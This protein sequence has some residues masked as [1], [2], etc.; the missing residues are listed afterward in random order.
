MRKSL[1]TIQQG[2]DLSAYD[3]KDHMNGSG[4]I[5]RPT[6]PEGMIGEFFKP[7]I[8]ANLDDAIDPGSYTLG[9]VESF[10]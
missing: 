9:S 6:I 8:K 10:V 5:I 2:T 4:E 3:Y 7:S 1:K